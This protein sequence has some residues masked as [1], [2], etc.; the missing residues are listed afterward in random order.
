MTT[1]I[2][3]ATSALGALA[4]ALTMTFVAPAFA[5]EP[6]DIV[7][8]SDAAMIEWQEDTTAS[9]NRA[10]ARDPTARRARP[11]QSHVEVA[12]TLGADGR[13]DNVRVTGGNGNWAAKR[14]AKYA[15]RTLD[16]LDQVP[17]TNRQ[18]ARFLASIVFADDEQGY[19]EQSA[20]AAKSREARFASVA[21]EDRPILLGG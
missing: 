12:F 7:V 3:Q 2:N 14:S 21:P 15:V 1:R 5:G 13:A 11:S 6:S 19:R 8:R 16:K 18:S 10:L 4:A 17:V 20:L 9:L